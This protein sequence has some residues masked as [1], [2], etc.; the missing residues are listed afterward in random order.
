MREVT[1]DECLISMPL[2]AVL[3]GIR[4]NEAF[5][6]GEVLIESGIRII[7]VTT[8]SPEPLESIRILAAAF[9]DY[10]IIGAGTVL[11]PDMV[12]RVAAVGGR[13]IVMPHADLAVI[14]AGKLEGCYVLPGIATPTEAF[15]A[16]NVGADGLK[17]FPAELASPKVLHAFRA[18]LPPETLVFPVGGITTDVMRKYWDAG[19]NGF[20]LGSNLYKSGKSLTKLKADA[21]R[22][23]STMKLLNKNSI[24]RFPN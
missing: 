20:G 14:K 12:L 15:A 3:R 4:P 22:Y 11:T 21:D 13:L 9:G 17:L 16:L 7:E 5:K 6:V 10:S 8:N 19:A 2:I 1:L 18:V 23:V 24:E